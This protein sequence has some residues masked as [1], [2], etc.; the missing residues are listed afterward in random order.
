LGTTMKLSMNF[1]NRDI[2]L[3][4]TPGNKQITVFIKCSGDEEYWDGTWDEVYVYPT[5]NELYIEVSYLNGVEGTGDRDYVKS[6]NVISV[7]DTWTPFTVT[8]NPTQEGF[9]FI[10]VVN[11]YNKTPVEY[12]FPLDIGED[13]GI[14]VDYTPIIE[15]VPAP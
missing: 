11:D 13:Y 10:D 3:W 6:N 1:V 2:P 9:A 12:I 4:L 5:N 7:I 15:D 8:I 14:F